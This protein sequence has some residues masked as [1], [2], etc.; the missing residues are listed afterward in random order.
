MVIPR[1]ILEEDILRVESD[2]LEDMPARSSLFV[3]PRG[4]INPQNK[5]I[6]IGTNLSSHL[7]DQYQIYGTVLK[8]RS[9]EGAIVRNYLDT[10]NL[11]QSTKHTYASDKIILT[12]IYNQINKWY[13]NVTPGYT[14]EILKAEQNEF[15]VKFGSI[16]WTLVPAIGTV[17]NIRKRI[18]ISNSTRS[19]LNAV[20]KSHSEFNRISK[21]LILLATYVY[22]ALYINAGGYFGTSIFMRVQLTSTDTTL[23]PTQIL[24]IAHSIAKQF[25]M[26]QIK[27]GLQETRFD[28]EQVH[29]HQDITQ[30][31]PHFSHVI[32]GSLD[33]EKY[34]QMIEACPDVLMKQDLRV[35]E[36]YLQ[37]TNQQLNSGG[38]YYNCFPIAIWL[39]KQKVKKP[40]EQLS[41][42]ELNRAWSFGCKFM[43]TLF[44]ENPTKSR[45][46]YEIIEKIRITGVNG[47]DSYYIYDYRLQLHSKIRYILKPK[48]HKIVII[49]FAGHAFTVMPK[50]D[51]TINTNNEPTIIL[52]PFKPP[53]NIRLGAGDIET[54]SDTVRPYA[55]SY[56]YEDGHIQ[57]FDASN[58]Q[59]C[60]S[61]FID[62]LRYTYDYE[63]HRKHLIAFHCGGI[64][65]F[66]FLIAAFCIRTDWRI[67]PKRFHEH[68][69]RI[70]F[71]EVISE[72]L[73]I[74]VPIKNKRRR[75]NIISIR[76]FDNYG[77]LPMS[78]MQASEL[79]NTEYKKLPEL[80]EHEVMS[81]ENWITYFKPNGKKY[82]EHDVLSLLEALQNA[83]KS[84]REIYGFQI[85]GNHYTISSASQYFFLSKFYCPEQFPLYTPSNH[86]HDLIQHSYYGGL[87]RCYY[88]G[89]FYADDYGLY[90]GEDHV[91]LSGLRKVNE[92]ESFTTYVK[93]KGEVFTHILHNGYEICDM[94]AKALYMSVMINK[95]FPY[96]E[97][98]YINFTEPPQNFFGF[99][100]GY[101]RGG[102]GYFSNYIR[103]KSS[104]GV[105]DP[106]I[107]DWIFI[108]ITS[109]EYNRIQ[110]LNHLYGYNFRFV[111]GI[112]YKKAYIFKQCLQYLFEIRETYP[113]DSPG[114]NCA[115]IAG[116]SIYGGFGMSRLTNK[117]IVKPND[118]ELRGYY[119]TGNLLGM[120]KF[121]AY[122]RTAIDSQARN[123]GI[124]SFTTSYGYDRVQNTRIQLDRNITDYSIKTIYTDTDSLHQIRKKNDVVWRDGTAP[125]YFCPEVINIRRFICIAKKTYAIEYIDKGIRK[126]KIRFK[127]FDHR[128]KYTIIVLHSNKEIHFYKPKINETGEFVSFEHFILLNK[129]YVFVLH[130]I[131]F[132]GGMTKFYGPQAK[133]DLDK[134]YKSITFDGKLYGGII[135][136]QG[137]VSPL[138]LTKGVL[139]SLQF[140]HNVL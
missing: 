125:G 50:S 54:T 112:R 76:F 33:P 93:G 42:Q 134:T 124:A 9:V 135:N 13:F 6:A 31:H 130:T 99:L 53:K 118:E 116:L 138:T 128:K 85:I 63:S 121:F 94:D 41:N 57:T 58:E 129:G 101:V 18:S 131:C 113:K 61:N 97:G 21:D 77:I 122:V 52:K 111:G 56:K 48:R 47:H 4:P 67:D 108:C 136:S 106:K 115:K 32:K 55:I 46:F 139:Y 109:I 102:S 88:V 107:I 71:F 140:L 91:D 84:Y 100:F 89:Q 79:Y 23:I 5:T 25:N 105:V 39:A 45:R 69:G 2:L 10:M 123:I 120:N 104:I 114:Y 29:I 74:N 126:Y 15:D 117:L 86:I 82:L 24:W 35:L 16:T 40:Y 75:H 20:S 19:F 78:L 34:E 30:N 60:L 103:Y 80:I 83:E 8:A 1:Y 44:E 59:D 27:Y 66:Y 132:T 68:N 14:F 3:H 96:G 65:D 43:K 51:I 7:N 90:E 38:S 81:E 11:Y 110:K 92:T 95:P 64:F 127:G 36:E 72:I 12:N 98:E 49:A 133:M 137:Y 26:F 119:S 37:Q 70:Y 28:I 62:S 17:H 22:R 87:C 73:D